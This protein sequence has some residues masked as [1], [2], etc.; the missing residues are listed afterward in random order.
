MR[1]EGPMYLNQ[2]NSTITGT[3]YGLQTLVRIRWAYMSFL[4]V[5]LG[6]TII[7]LLFTIAATCR[8]RMQILKED[9]LATMCALSA[10][11][12]TELGGLEDMKGLKGR[13]RGMRVGLERGVD[14]AVRGLDAV[15]FSSSSLQPG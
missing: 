1:K 13:A 7:V 4:A 14:G 6:L 10:G 5:Q 15:P 2:D 3:A 8:S 11:A 12:K 9:S